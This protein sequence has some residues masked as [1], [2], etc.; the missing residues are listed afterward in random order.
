MVW[1]GPVSKVT[2]LRTP[3]IPLSCFIS[4]FMEAETKI[5]FC[6]IFTKIFLQLNYN[7]E[8]SSYKPNNLG[9]K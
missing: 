9:C 7:A 3:Q 4:D 5:K 8:F 2:G 1:A 6:D